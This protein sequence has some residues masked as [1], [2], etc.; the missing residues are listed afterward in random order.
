MRTT[1]TLDTHNIPIRIC[2]GAHMARSALYIMAASILYLFNIS[3]ALDSAGDPI[4]VKPQF[5]E[6]S[7]VS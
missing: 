1:T 4:E 5:P 6:A 2:P 7:F 3:P